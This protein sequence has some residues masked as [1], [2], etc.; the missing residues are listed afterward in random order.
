[1]TPNPAWADKVLKENMPALITMMGAEMTPRHSY[2]AKDTWRELG[3]CGAYG[4]VYSTR[5]AGTVF[6]ITTDKSEAAFVSICL[7]NKVDWPDGIVRYLGVIELEGEVSAYGILGSQPYGLWR[8]EAY[9]FDDVGQA[10]RELYGFRDAAGSIKKI[11]REL[12]L[13]E[14]LSPVLAELKYLASAPDAKVS[15]AAAEITY[16]LTVCRGNAETMANSS[17][18]TVAR[19]KRVG[20]ALLYYMD[21]GMLLADVHAK[22]VAFV[23]RGGE[24]YLAITDPGHMVPLKREFMKTEVTKVGSLFAEKWN[25]PPMLANPRRIW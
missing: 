12:D 16:W 1:M 14:T 24:E 8:E 22:N 17:H 3:P 21:M 4:C 9:H 13:R 23:K 2:Q 10:P 18:P 25:L 5:T 20:E 11:V 7:N 19:F 15:H 6:K